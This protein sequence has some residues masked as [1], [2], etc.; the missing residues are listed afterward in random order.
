MPSEAHTLLELLESCKENIPEQTYLTFCDHL[1]NVHELERTPPV[2]TLWSVEYVKVNCNSRYYTRH[3]RICQEVSPRVM[4]ND[5]WAVG[6]LC[7][8]NITRQMAED[9]VLPHIFRHEN[10]VIIVHSIDLFQ[11]GEE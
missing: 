5:H 1:Q 9:Y 3:H 2:R 4:H 7:Q 8:S 6:F 10:S 11:D